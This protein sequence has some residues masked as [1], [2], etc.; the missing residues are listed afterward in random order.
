[1]DLDLLAAETLDEV[2]QLLDL[3]F[4]LAVLILDHALHQLAGLVPELVVADV[5]LDLAVVDVNDVGADRY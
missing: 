3:F 1:M 5:H 2:L 4:V